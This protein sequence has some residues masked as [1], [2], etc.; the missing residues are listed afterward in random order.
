MDKLVKKRRGGPR[1]FDRDQAIDIAMRLFWRHG[2]EGVSLNDLTAAIGIAP[3]SLYAAFGSKAGL[4]R[5]ALDRYSGLPRAL[6]NLGE[7]AN[8][9]EAV[10]TLLDRA[11][12]A[13]TDPDEE[14]GCMISSGMIQCGEAHAA[15]ARELAERRS[16]MRDTIALKL[17]P[18]LDRNH[19]AS[20]SRYLVTIL[21]GLSV[22][23]RD[24]ASR[25]DLKQ[26]ASE[27][28]AGV[29]A[30]NLPDYKRGAP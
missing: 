20:L 17:E 18:W 12:D 16:M 23:A 6:S 9:Y 10:E 11:I 24:G 27:V 15:L 13:V 8:L 7:T 26:I 29:K 2:Y 14:R 1:T 21:Q 5:E 4:Y 3:P 22:Q 28:V 30:R 19:A 25:E